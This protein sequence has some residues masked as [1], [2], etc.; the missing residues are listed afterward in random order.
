MAILPQPALDLECAS[1]FVC[2]QLKMLSILN[3]IL[4]DDLFI[5]GMSKRERKPINNFRCE[6][7]F[8]FFIQREPH[9]TRHNFCLTTNSKSCGETPA[10]TLK[11][12]GKKEKERK[13]IHSLESDRLGGKK[14]PV[15]F[16]VIGVEENACAIMAGWSGTLFAINVVV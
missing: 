10:F 11:S 4:E 16:V 13:I 5:F 3:D 6:C 15:R 14:Y 2:R 1:T 9:Y 7:N 8:A 12:E